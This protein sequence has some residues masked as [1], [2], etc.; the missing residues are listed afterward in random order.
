MKKVNPKESLPI[1]QI[2]EEEEVKRRKK[3]EIKIFNF[4][5]SQRPKKLCQGF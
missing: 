4:D 1:K 3:I 2:L 5:G